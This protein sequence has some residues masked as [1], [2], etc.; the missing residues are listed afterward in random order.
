MAQHRQALDEEQTN[1]AET[2]EL[3]KVSLRSKRRWCNCVSE[4]Q[5]SSSKQRPR[6]AFGRQILSAGKNGRPCAEAAAARRELAASAGTQRQ[7]LDEERARNGALTRELAKTPLEVQ[8]QAACEDCCAGPQARRARAIVHAMETRSR[9]PTISIVPRRFA[10]LG[11]LAIIGVAQPSR[12]V[13]VFC[14]F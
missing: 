4:K 13:F 5:G 9:W 8:A 12:N 10:G 14:H 1:G 3:A 11:P 7:A 6:R 2:I